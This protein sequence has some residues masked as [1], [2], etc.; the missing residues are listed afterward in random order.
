M[1]V[2]GSGA[3]AKQALCVYCGASS[4]SDPVFTEAAHQ[5]GT[6]MA[7][8][9][10]DLVYG[11]GGIGLMGTVA[12]AVLAGGGHVTGV[13][14][15]FLKSREV[16]LKEI[17][18][19]I[20]TRDMHERKMLMFERADAFVALPGGIGT[21]EELIEQLTWAQLGQHKKPV[22]IAN[23][24]GFWDPLVALLGH[25]HATGFLN[26]PFMPGAAD[27]RYHVVTHTR[28]VVPLTLALLKSDG[29]ANHDADIARR[30]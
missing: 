25:M 21:L 22:I 28:E 13:I 20:V 1:A 15:D 6:D 3:R 18:E 10:L 17:Q 11:A 23:I 14:P 30:F 26:K 7:K 2:G 12:R 27:A 4:G 9:G 24:A 8:S 5:L 19:L 16:D 29:M